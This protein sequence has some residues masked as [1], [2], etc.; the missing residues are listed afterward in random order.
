MLADFD[1]SATGMAAQPFLL[2][3]DKAG[4]GRHVPDLLWSADSRQALTMARPPRQ[5]CRGPQVSG[6]LQ[7]CRPP[8]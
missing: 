8:P 5:H 2:G 7:G 4:L 6:N 3:R 1:P